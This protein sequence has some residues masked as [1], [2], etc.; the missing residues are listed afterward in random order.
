MAKIE[1]EKIERD[2]FKR[3]RIIPAFEIISKLS[4]FTMIAKLKCLS[5]S[6]PNQIRLQKVN[7]S[8]KMYKA[9]FKYL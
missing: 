3:T 7:S 5:G 9:F 2:R 8:M 4:D 1:R 6:K